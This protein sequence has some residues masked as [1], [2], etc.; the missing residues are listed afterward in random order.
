MSGRWKLIHKHGK[1]G[2]RYFQIAL[3]GL[4]VADVFP[5]AG[6]YR[7]KAEP[8]WIIQQAQLIVDTMNAEG[9]SVGT[10]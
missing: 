4:R 9:Q 5:D 6:I 3:D 2:A 10:P 7:G 8:E 1:L